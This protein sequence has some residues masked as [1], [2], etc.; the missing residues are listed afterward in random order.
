MCEYERR[1]SILDEKLEGFQM[2]PAQPSKF[3]IFQLIGRSIVPS[4]NQS[5]DQTT[6]KV[7]S[8]WS[9]LT[10]APPKYKMRRKILREKMSKQF[11]KVEK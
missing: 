3:D 7:F 11:R 8:A 6:L 4:V 5:I 1:S 10:D 9:W 2:P